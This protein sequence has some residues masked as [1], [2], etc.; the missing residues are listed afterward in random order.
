MMKEF[1]TVRVVRPLNRCWG[2]L[3]KPPHTNTRRNFFKAGGALEKATQRDG[4]VSISRG[5]LGS[6]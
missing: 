4:G 2:A 3:Y 5:D 6:R 1:F